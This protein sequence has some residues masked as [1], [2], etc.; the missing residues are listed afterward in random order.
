MSTTFKAPS[1]GTYRFHTRL[2]PTNGASAAGWSPT[3]S[4][5]VN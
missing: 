1:T 2:H 4:I 5:T 3:V